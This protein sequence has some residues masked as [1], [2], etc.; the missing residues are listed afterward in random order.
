ML[1]NEISIK[2]YCC[3]PILLLIDRKPFLCAAIDIT[4]DCGPEP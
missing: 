3:E 4:K 1:D 2:S